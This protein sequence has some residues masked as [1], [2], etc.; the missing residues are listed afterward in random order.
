[1]NRLLN[2]PENE[3]NEMLAGYIASYPDR[4]CK[5]SG[6]N[7]LLNKNEKDKVS[8][9]IGAGGGNEPWPIG[10]VGE[11]LADACSLGNVFAAPTAKSI[12]NAIRHVPHEKGVLCIAT[13]HAGDV[14]N[15]ELVAGLAEME[16]IHTKQI[17]VSDDVTSADI[18]ER[19][20]RRGI[21]GVSLV[22]KIAAAASEAGLSLEEVYGI[23]SM[24]NQN[25]HT[26]SVTTSPAYVLE[27]GQPAYELPDGEIEYGMGFNG[28]KGIE[29]TALQA[30]DEVMEK[31]V[32]MLRE[33][34][35]LTS[36]DEIAV[37]LNPYK[38]T[39]VLESYILMRKCLEI[40]E[41]SRIRV[42]DS[43]VDSLFP[44]QG[45]GGFTLTFL[46]MDESFK[47]YYDKPADSPLFRKREVSHE[48]GTSRS[49]TGELVPPTVENGIVKVQNQK[50]REP[51]G[52]VRQMKVTPIKGPVKSDGRTIYKEDLKEMMLYVS[53]KIVESEPFL[54][55][56]DL[57]IGD[58]DHGTGM[59]RGFSEVQKELRD[60]EP[61]S[62]ED[63]FLFVGTTL[64][65]TMGGASGVLFGTVF[66][67]GLTK[68]EA[69]ENIGITDFYEIFSRALEA[70]K[71]RGRARVGDKTMVDALEP[72]VNGLRLASEAGDNMKEGLSK[73]LQ[74]AKEGV[75]YTRTVKAR[76]GRARYFGEK[77][78]GLQ[79]A[80]ATSVWIIFR[81]MYEWICENQ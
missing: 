54:T 13:N 69:H 34:M 18:T 16:G 72:A 64:L 79:D 77:A 62:A 76:F 21:A 80:G 65:D 43:Y 78:I 10:Y 32:H 50:N 28:E 74:G 24:A 11:G 56:I 49:N 39:T 41:K 9:V 3:V 14:L 22:V 66:I 17:Y 55:E 47:K 63:V 40:L 4:F 26:V 2:N 27:T 6:Y 51:L 67:S 35:D 42:Y 33:D 25:T 61:L 44:T 30:A 75:E 57:K 37:F 81:S 38:A 8:I 48:T 52:Q 70:L 29:R 19:E 20:E 12:L 46:R 73:A 58:G 71:Q 45:A 60:Y 31:M 53:E 15:F 59:K 7:V 1:M 68:R 5:L 36:G 23:A